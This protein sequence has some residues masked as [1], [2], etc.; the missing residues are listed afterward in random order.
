VKKDYEYKKAPIVTYQVDIK[1]EEEYLHTVVSGIRN[2]QNVMAVTTDVLKACREH[3]INKALIDV[4]QLKGRLSVIDSF[5]IAAKEFANI[6]KYNIINKAVIVDNK[7]NEERYRF[8]ENV[9]VNRGYNIRFF[10]DSD[11]ALEWLLKG[12][13]K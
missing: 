1:A 4:R 10:S 2:R 11:I 6:R 8:F 9:A 5:F 7:E 12:V 13:P 3:N